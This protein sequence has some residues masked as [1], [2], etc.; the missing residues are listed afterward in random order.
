MA[1]IANLRYNNIKN[2]NIEFIR[3][4]TKDT[5]KDKTKIKKRNGKKGRMETR[6]TG[7]RE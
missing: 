4:K 6:K 1:D 3:Q 2:N 5:T 7:W